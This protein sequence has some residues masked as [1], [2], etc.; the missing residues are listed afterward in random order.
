VLLIPL[1]GAAPWI[2]SWRNRSKYLK[3][4]KELRSIEKGL[5]GPMA[6]RAGDIEARLD[7]IEDTLDKV[8]ISTAFLDELYTLKEHIQ[9]VREKL[10]RRL[11]EQPKDAE[12]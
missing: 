9:I 5:R 7:G 2:Y 11:S 6:L 8:R 12:S 10:A 3:L 1:I 4:Y